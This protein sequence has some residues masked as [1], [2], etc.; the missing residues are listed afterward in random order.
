[1]RHILKLFYLMVF[2]FLVILF[3]YLFFFD[4]PAPQKDIEYIVPNEQFSTHQ[5]QTI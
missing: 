1:M 5:I 4:I 3:G 2:S